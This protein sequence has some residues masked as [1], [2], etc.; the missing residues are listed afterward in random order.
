MKKNKGQVDKCLLYHHKI[1][2]TWCFFGWFLIH[3]LNLCMFVS[4]RYVFVKDSWLKWLNGIAS[5]LI[6]VG[7]VYLQSSGRSSLGNS[8]DR[9][10]QQN[11]YT[12]NW[13][14]P[15]IRCKKRYLFKTCTCKPHS[16][17]FLDFLTPGFRSVLF[18]AAVLHVA[19]SENP[20]HAPTM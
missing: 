12:A 14:F 3:F 8:F 19:R 20:F 2:I 4:V 1:V 7:C 17:S 16:K 18:K 9:S 5:I 13:I 11:I 10:S 15:C 6:Y